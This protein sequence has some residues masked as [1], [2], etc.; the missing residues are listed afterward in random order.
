MWLTEINSTI[1]SSKH[2]DNFKQHKELSQSR[3]RTA[4]DVRTIFLSS[5]L[6]VLRMQGNQWRIVTTPYCQRVL[7]LARRLRTSGNCTSDMGEGLWK[8]ADREDHEWK[9]RNFKM[10]KASYWIWKDPSAPKT[11]DNWEKL[12]A[13]AYRE[14]LQSPE[15]EG[16]YFIRLG[17]DLHD[18]SEVIFIEATCEQYKDWR[19]EHDQRKYLNRFDELAAAL[20][21]SENDK[22][23]ILSLNRYRPGNG[24]EVFFNL[25][26]RKSFVMSLEVSPEE[27]AA[28]SSQKRDKDR[29]AAAVEKSGGS[30]IKAIK[31]L[32][33]KR[34]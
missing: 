3:T 7:F 4:A 25:G 14:F 2:F 26:N 27:A 8:G 33:T 24:R 30:Y 19:R 18:N 28:F 11:P 12:S 17:D 22:S 10:A 15:S 20:S 9:E 13:K 5:V 29:L 16:R 23:M 32:C 1:A 31:K 6:F 34:I 21:L